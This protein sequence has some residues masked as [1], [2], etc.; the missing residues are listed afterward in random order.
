MDSAKSESLSQVGEIQGVRLRSRR[1]MSGSVIRFIKKKPLGAVGLGILFFFMLLAVFG[2]QLAPLSPTEISREERLVAPNAAHWF[3]TDTVGRDIFS[4]ILVGA[5]L[6]IMV[7][8]VVVVISKVIGT[9]L[10]V[11]SAYI[12]GKFDL[13]LQRV[14]DAWSSFPTL[15]LAIAIMSVAGQSIMNVI[16][17]LTITALPRTIRIV[18]STALAVKESM[19]VDAARAMGASH[20]RIMALHVLPNCMA[21]VIVIASASLGGIILAESSLSFLGVG[22]PDETISWGAMLS[23]S[24]Q[25]YFATAPW[26]GIFPGLALTL[27]VFGVNIFGDALR[28]V[29]DPRLRRG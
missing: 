12:G 2:A 24:Q 3:G 20:V 28:D 22:T 18:R 15:I 27:V 23:G 6:S 29:L 21:T 7:G 25:R 19:Y 16:I 13:T 10:G 9:A 11:M 26:I 1:T 17:A 14:V 8:V 4:R 5:R